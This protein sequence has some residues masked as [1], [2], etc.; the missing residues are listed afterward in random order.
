MYVGCA[1][2]LQRKVFNKT[3]KPPTLNRDGGFTV[4]C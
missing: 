2:D 1:I 4:S 3:A